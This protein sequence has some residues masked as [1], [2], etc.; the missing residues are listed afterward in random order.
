MRV[1]AVRKGYFG[2]KIRDAGEVFDL[3]DALI[4]GGVSWVEAEGETFAHVQPAEGEIG[5]TTRKRGRKSKLA[6]APEPPEGNGLEAA[7]GGPPP[8]WIPGNI[9]D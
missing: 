5:S 1:T 2:G 7:L 4:Q 3:P 6:S 8:D 9:S